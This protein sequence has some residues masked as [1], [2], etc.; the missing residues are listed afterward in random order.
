MGSNISVYDML[1]ALPVLVGEKPLAVRREKAYRKDECFVTWSFLITIKPTKP[2][3][4][5]VLFHIV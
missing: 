3:W 5:W 2:N 4:E 1:K